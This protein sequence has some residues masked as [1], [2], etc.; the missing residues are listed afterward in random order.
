MKLLA[1]LPFAA[2]LG[3]CDFVV[4]AP[5]GDIA[6]Q[7]RDLVVISTVLMLII[8]L[9]VMAL[10]VFFAWRYRQSNAAAPYEP[11][12]DHSTQLEL[13]IWSAPLLIIICLGALT[14]MGTHLLDPYRSLGRIAADKPI[15]SKDAPLNV[16]VV[17]LDWKWLFIYP[18]YGVAAV[19]ELAAPV[20]RPIRFR[21][22]A[23]SVMNSFYIPALAGQI[24]AMP[25]ME[26]KLHAVANKEG[27][28][29]GFSANYSG[30]GFSGMHFEFKSLSA[31]DFDKWIG[32]AKA[33]ANMLGRTDYLQ[34]ERPSQNDPVRLYRSVD[35]DLY[36]AVLNMCVE[37][38]KMC[39]SEMMAIDAK[40]GLGREG[41][42]NTLP[43]TY[44][45]Y[46]RRGAPLG[47]EPTFVAGI[48]SMDEIKDAPSR[49]VTAPLDLTPL[50]GFGLKRPPFSPAHPSSTSL[51]L[52]QRPKS[53]S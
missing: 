29:R 13:V 46:A 42:N 53:E 52:G 8:V 28:Y 51:L 12:W 39:M 47:S 11:E 35:R 36:K 3:G 48:C 30:A 6:A 38:G 49:E 34:L 43:L 23:S 37:P 26:T 17:A 31:T 7:Q 20:D 41:F 45:K 44:D 16:E 19:N 2:L 40:G 5:A 18:D 25:G 14:W 9:P 32:S 24:Y 10:T 27:T 21:I 50:R 1:L 22:T 15:K 33:S 4:L